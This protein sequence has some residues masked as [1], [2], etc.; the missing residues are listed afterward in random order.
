MVGDETHPSPGDPQ[1]CRASAAHRGCCE[2][3]LVVLLLVRHG[4][5]PWGKLAARAPGMMPPLEEPPQAS[6]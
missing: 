1:R 3:D 4:V 2:G 5:A 6:P